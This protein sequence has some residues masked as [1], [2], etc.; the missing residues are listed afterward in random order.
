MCTIRLESINEKI[1][2]NNAVAELKEGN[3]PISKSLESEE[4]SKQS[5]EKEFAEGSKD[6]TYRMIDK[7]HTYFAIVDTSVLVDQNPT[8]VIDLK[9]F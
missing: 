7:Q 8:L 5:L 2:L 1:L 4:T 9:T 6:N 3:F